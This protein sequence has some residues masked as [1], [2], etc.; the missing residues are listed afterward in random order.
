MSPGVFALAT[1]AMDPTARLT[2]ETLPD[3]GAGRSGRSG[4]K[5][6]SS[7]DDGIVVVGAFYSE[8][9]MIVLVLVVIG[10]AA[11]LAHTAPFPFLLEAFRPSRS[12]WRSPAAGRRSPV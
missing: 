9:A 7:L 3:R 12:V 5:T 10:G 1:V 8:A 4:R 11:V 2:K 6:R